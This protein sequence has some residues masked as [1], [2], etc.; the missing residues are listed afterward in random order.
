M[1]LSRSRTTA[2]ATVMMCVAI[3]QALGQFPQTESPV[4]VSPGPVTQNLVYG[5]HVVGSQISMVTEVDVFQFLGSAGDQ[6]RV[7]IW[8]PNSLDPRVR[9]L[10]H[11]GP[12]FLADQVCGG[13]CGMAVPVTLTTSG[14]HSIFVSDSATNETGSY[15]LQLERVPPAVAPPALPHSVA[16]NDSISPRT[17]HDF[18]TFQ[19]EANGIYDITV[20]TPNSL[21]PRLE[22]FD[23]TGTSVADMAC[24]GSCSMTIPLTPTVSGQY[25][26][27]VSDSGLNE[28]GSYQLT[29]QCLFAPSGCPPPGG[30]VV[31][32]AGQPAGAGSVEIMN[33]TPFPNSLFVTAI[34]TD[35][36]NNTSP[37]GGWWGGLHISVLDLTS[38]IA[39]GRLPYV[40][41]TDGNGDSLF[42]LPPGS[43]PPG[44]P[45][46]YS[47]TRT[48]DTTMTT[49]TSTSNIVSL[50]IL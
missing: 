43:L 49:V 10:D 38:Q 46:F 33:S 30:V 20:F 44:L 31:L 7:L 34:S 22:I 39:T 15:T 1:A 11:S 25:L 26:V 42:S 4:T 27:V 2:I 19:A 24:G 29:F 17:D 45:T 3:G 48:I 12:T 14:L 37:G 8:T 50:T 13:S 28:T 40:G 47:V 18:V 9:V 21:D 35:P 16:I 41:M 5:D 23:P 36:M 6:I 32:M